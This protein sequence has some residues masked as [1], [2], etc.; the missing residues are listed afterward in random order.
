LQKSLCDSTDRD[1]KNRHVPQQ[2]KNTNEYHETDPEQNENVN[3]GE[4]AK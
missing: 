2:F 4:F 3:L 1:K